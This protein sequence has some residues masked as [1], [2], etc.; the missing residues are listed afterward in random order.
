[1]KHFSHFNK[2]IV[3]YLFHRHFIFLLKDK[4]LNKA[5][6]FK[7]KSKHGQMVPKLPFP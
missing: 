5:F 1:M 3:K 4:C 6:F 2:N 7:Q